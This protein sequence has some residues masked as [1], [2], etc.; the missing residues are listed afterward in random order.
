MTTWTVY[1]LYL[2]QLA[3]QAGIPKQW[4]PWILIADQLVFAITDVLT[5]FWLDRVR[6]GFARIGGWMLGVT[7]ISCA[8][9]LVLPFAG[10]LGL[11]PLPAPLLGAI[12]VITAAYVTATELQKHCF[13]RSRA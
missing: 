4:V 2:P 3:E 5:G 12:V 6:A 9:F 10:A 1:V 8:A 11:V 13:C 7:A